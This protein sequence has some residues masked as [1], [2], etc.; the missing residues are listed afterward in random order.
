MSAEAAVIRIEVA[1]IFGFPLRSSFAFITNLMSWSQYWPNFVRIEHDGDP[2]WSSPG[3]RLTV[4]QRFLGREVAL[5]LQ[6][7]EFRPD[8]IRYR[9]RQTGLPELTHERHFVAL[10]DGF[11]Y[12]LVVAYAPRTGWRGL[13]DRVIF[14]RAVERALHE[15][16]DNLWEEFT[17]AWCMAPPCRT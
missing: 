16:I 17:S 3:D 5:H 13:F 2:R 11:E 12:R 14:K 9:S 1:T 7:E 4:V 10:A 6:L 15:T 8:F